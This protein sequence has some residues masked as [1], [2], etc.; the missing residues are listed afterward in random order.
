MFGPPQTKHEA[1]RAVNI[2]DIRAGKAVL[3]EQAKGA[4]G[5]IRKLVGAVVK[6]VKARDGGKRDGG[7][8]GDGRERERGRERVKINGVGNGNREGRAPPKE[9][10][11]VMKLDKVVKNS[12]AS[13]SGSGSAAAV[14]RETP[15]IVPAKQPQLQTSSS[16]SSLH[17][18]S[19]L[20]TPILSLPTHLLP[21]TQL[22]PPQNA[23]L[24]IAQTLDL[25]QN[26][27]QSPSPSLNVE[28]TD[29]QLQAQIQAE[30]E[31]EMSRER[32]R[33]QSRERDREKQVYEQQQARELARKEEEE[34]Q[35]EIQEQMER[36]IQAQIESETRPALPPRPRVLGSLSSRG[37]ND[38]GV[39]ASISK[40]RAAH[41][42]EN[43][44]DT[45]EDG[46]GEE[47]EDRINEAM[48][49]I[50]ISRIQLPRPH[51]EKSSEIEYLQLPPA[52]FGSL[53]ERFE[54][55]WGREDELVLERRGWRRK[56]RGVLGELIGIRERRE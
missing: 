49:E 31:R 8:K 10:D 37:I 3:A 47:D 9:Q 29:S 15:A 24:S 22:P 21:P 20:V 42:S 28:F 56:F 16:S 4:S 39:H 19:H 51:P 2:W 7:K 6:D 27:T 30:I 38:E 23:P 1:K 25:P 43:E 52:W 14:P 34:M 13:G 5:E 33:E 46:D 55:L 45:G 41:A 12:G 35:R 11:R 54:D 32:A 40:L 18:T 50:A 17:R 48:S 53:I 44:D 36:E 26:I